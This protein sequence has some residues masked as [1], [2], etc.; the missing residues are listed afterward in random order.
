MN[1]VRLEM[2]TKSYDHNGEKSS[3]LNGEPQLIAVVFRH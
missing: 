2:S 3:S 1:S